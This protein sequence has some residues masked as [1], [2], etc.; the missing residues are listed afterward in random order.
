MKKE[1]KELS[2]RRFI[3]TGAAAATAASILSIPALA[4][5]KS[6][7]LP[8]NAQNALPNSAMLT[9]DPVYTESTRNFNE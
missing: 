6:K 1:N 8:V 5:D 9:N 2:R 3:T 4:A 7:Q